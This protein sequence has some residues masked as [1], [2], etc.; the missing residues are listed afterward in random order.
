[1]DPTRTDPQGNPVY[2]L[3][4][5]QGCCPTV[6]TDQTN[7]RVTITDDDG[8]TVVLTAEQWAAAKTIPT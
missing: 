2:T 8:G 1:M 7:G 4:G 3:C 5:G 6:T